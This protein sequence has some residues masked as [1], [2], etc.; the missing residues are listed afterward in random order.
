MIYL[1]TELTSPNL[2]ILEIGILESS[3]AETYQS[4]RWDEEDKILKVKLNKVLDGT[5]KI[6]LDELI[7]GI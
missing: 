2:D 4:L 6:L 7:A 3:L 5:E 1:Y